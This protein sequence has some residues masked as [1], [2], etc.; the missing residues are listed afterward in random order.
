MVFVGAGFRSFALGL[1]LLH[2]DEVELD[3]GTDGAAGADEG[4][5]GEV[6]GA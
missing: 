6:V 4:V 3:V 5:D 2:G 1:V